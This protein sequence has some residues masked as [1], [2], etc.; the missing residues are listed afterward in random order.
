MHRTH[1]LIQN[2]RGNEAECCWQPLPLSY[3]QLQPWF[4]VHS[5]HPLP[6][7]TT[8]HRMTPTNALTQ[9]W[10]YY[11]FLMQCFTILLHFSFVTATK[12]PDKSIL[13]EAWTV[14]Y[15][16][17][18][19]LYT[20]YTFCD[21]L[22]ESKLNKWMNSICVVILVLRKKYFELSFTDIVLLCCP[23]WSRVPQH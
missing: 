10:T 11:M 23:G 1:N 9:I 13:Y 14:P 21:C 18:P 15:L 6:W 20:D 17:L 16:T 12:Q 3:K 2:P 22:L 19:V 8:P 4:W 5:T 7:V